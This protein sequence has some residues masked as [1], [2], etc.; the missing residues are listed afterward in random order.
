MTTHAEIAT[1]L[2]SV[3]HTVTG[4]AQSGQH[5]QGWTYAT[6]DDVYTAIRG[7]LVDAGVAFTADTDAVTIDD[8]A[9]SE[10][11]PMRIARAAVALTF[12]CTQSGESVTAYSHGESDATGAGA[13]TKA[14]ADAVKNGL[15]RMFLVPQNEPATRAVTPRN[16][17]GGATTPAPRQN[18]A[19][20]GT[21]TYTF[22]FG[23]AK[24]Q[25]IPETETAQL[26]WYLD[27]ALDPEDGKWGDSNRDVRAAI[28][29]ELDRREGIS[30]TD[31]LA[32]AL[33]ATEVPATT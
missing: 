10:G 16:N 22:K 24:G 8:W 14:Q 2:A 3:M 9:T 5:Q 11:R 32:T 13:V 1:K 12:T 31:R 29:A 19:R 26:H 20:G 21:G 18:A 7:A 23:R 27:N 30:G 6:A 15:L 17:S 28:H 4:V 25:T 33:D